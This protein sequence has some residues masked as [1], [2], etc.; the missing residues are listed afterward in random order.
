VRR[1]DGAV[2]AVQTGHTAADAA[3]AAVAAPLEAALLQLLGGV[4]AFATADDVTWVQG[5]HPF[6]PWPRAVSV[7]PS[8]LVQALARRNA[9]LS[10]VA[11]ATALLNDLDR[12]IGATAVVRTAH[13]KTQR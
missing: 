2:V 9:V 1:A 13:R 4:V 6:V 11:V 5:A 12:L 8:L 7:P 3:A 10:R